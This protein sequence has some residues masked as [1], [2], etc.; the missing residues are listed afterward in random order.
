M[1]CLKSINISFRKQLNIVFKRHFRPVVF[2]LFLLLRRCRKIAKEIFGNLFTFLNY[3]VKSKQF[4]WDSLSVLLIFSLK[5][6]FV[7][8]LI[9]CTC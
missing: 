8:L 5:M 3:T 1:Q 7:L 6:L 2:S 4:L 9:F